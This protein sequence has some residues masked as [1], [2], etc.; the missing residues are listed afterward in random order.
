MSAVLVPDGP[1]EGLLWHRG[2]PMA[3][4]RAIVEGTA[5]AQLGRREVVTV[6]GPARHEWLHS[7]T[8]GVFNGLE[9]GARV[10]ALVLSP[11]GHVTHVLHAVEDGERLWMF[12]RAGSGSSLGDF[13][14]SM[15]FRTRVVVERR[16]Q[17]RVLWAGANAGDVPAGL[18]PDLDAPFGD[19]SVRIAASGIDDEDE[20]AAGTW[21]WE[22]LRIAAGIPRIG[23]DT[24]GRTLPNELGLYATALDKGCYCGQET[25]ARVHNVGHPPR[26][27]VR[28]L[29]DGMRARLPAA[30]SDLL[31]DGRPVGFIGASAQ[32]F[33]DG[34]I[35][36]GLVKRTVPVDARLVVDGVDAAQEVLVDPDI[37]LHVEVPAHL[38]GRPV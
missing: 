34:P 33:L 32:H 10:D 27:L 35:G 30:G 14:E 16:P 3:E 22:A 31:L 37:G 24:D 26:R 18:A 19:G 11:A 25:V 29:L 28:L 6:T 12:G 4:Q 20:R 2:R 7:L 23:V 13:L 5:V 15:V 9:A 17:A 36:L 21:A 1:D 38:R 8:T